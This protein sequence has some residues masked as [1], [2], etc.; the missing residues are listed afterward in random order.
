MKSFIICTLHQ[1]LFAW[2]YP[3]RRRTRHEARMEGFRSTQKVWIENPKR[4][5]LFSKAYLSRMV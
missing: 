5:K 1:I 4:K 3:R 2:F